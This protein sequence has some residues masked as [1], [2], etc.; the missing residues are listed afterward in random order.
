MPFFMVHHLAFSMNRVGATMM[1]PFVFLFFCAPVAGI[2]SDRMGSRLLCTAGM[3]M[4]T[5][6]LFLLSRLSAQA[7]TMDMAWRLAL[8]GIG[9]AVFIPPN[10]AIAMSA[11]PPHHRG[12]ASGS[13]ATARN[14][15]MVIGVAT[16]A[17]IFNGTF[18][19]LNSGQSLKIYTPALETS[20]MSA[21]QKSMLA[22][23]AVAAC[24]VVV[25]YLRGRDSGR[26][27]G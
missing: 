13:V 22:G 19:S 4:L 18:R 9:I 25:A 26:S 15:G 23:A 5:A 27:N 24:G 6:A 20:F 7:T 21:F 12:I 3:A 2:L 1:I 17:L 11:V 10:S 14:L 8:A 16:A